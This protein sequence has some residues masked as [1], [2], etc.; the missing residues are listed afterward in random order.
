VLNSKTV[1]ILYSFTD[2]IRWTF[3]RAQQVSGTYWKAQC[4]DESAG[5]KMERKDRL[6]DVKQKY[7]RR[8]SCMVRT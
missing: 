2:N 1:T 3:T 8:E 4:R 5:K 6:T 7:G